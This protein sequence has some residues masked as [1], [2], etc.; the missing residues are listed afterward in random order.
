MAP[1]ILLLVCGLL[2]AASIPAYSATIRVPADQPTIQQ[3]IDAASPGDLVLVA[4]GTYVGPQNR[5]LNCH[6]KSI[7][8]RGDGGPAAIIIDCQ[9][10]GRGFVFSS[11]ETSALLITGF[12]ITNGTDG[13]SQEGGGGLLILGSSPTIR[14]CVLRQNSAVSDFGNGGG[15]GIACYYST[16]TIDNCSFIENTS[17]GTNGA[18]GGGLAAHTSALTVSRCVFTRNEAVGWRSE[19]GGMYSG[20]IEGAPA[21]SDCVF[22]GNVAYYGGGI[23]AVSAG[24]TITGTDFLHNKA[25]GSHAGG[26]SGGPCTITD[27]RFIGNSAAGGAGGLEIQSSSE[28]SRCSFIANSCVER[29]GGV[30]CLNSTSTFTDC[31]MAWNSADRGGG[32]ACLDLHYLI[33]CT[34]SH[35]SAAQGSG[36]YPYGGLAHITNSI[37]SFGLGSPAVSCGGGG[38]AAFWCSDV[39]GNEGG[40]WVGCITYYGGINNNFSFDPL[41]CDSGAWNFNLCSDSPCA[42]LQNPD[43]ELVGALQVGCGAC[44]VTATTPATWGAVKFLYG[45]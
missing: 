19:G 17:T 15:G 43:C 30:W 9:G 29:G 18:V 31:V 24:T 39:Y 12:T 32:F 10:A 4:P 20:L 23:S 34:I 27:C 44:G 3:G 13:G 6:G 2:L 45:R 40:D 8:I 11:G 16:A 37:I 26:M 25:I 21:I 36:V 38:G 1:R 41:F 42:P 22:S 28:V 7:E 14:D 5:N 33:R 35:N